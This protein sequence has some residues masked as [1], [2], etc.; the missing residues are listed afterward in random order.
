MVNA[1]AWKRITLS[2]FFSGC[3]FLLLV[4]G[5]TQQQQDQPK[6]PDTTSLNP[7]FRYSAE[8]VQQAVKAGQD[9]AKHGRKPAVFT[10]KFKQNPVWTRGKKG[11]AHESYVWAIGINAESLSLLA[12]QRAAQYENDPALEKYK[13]TGTY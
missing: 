2:L 7:V 8:E 4:C 3:C 12:Y 6:K 1:Q 5:H 11:K 9:A 10:D 13:A